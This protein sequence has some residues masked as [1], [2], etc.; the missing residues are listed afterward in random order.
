MESCHRAVVAKGLPF[1]WYTSYEADSELRCFQVVRQTNFHRPM[2][3]LRL[4]LIHNDLTWKVYLAD[5]S[6]PS[7]CLVLKDFPPRVSSKFVSDLIDTISVSNIC[8]GNYEERFI[9]LAKARKGKFL[10][11]SGEIVALLDD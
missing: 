1:T 6:V 5:H 4:L 11:V 9:A 2:V 8:S 3:V 10:S 7:Q